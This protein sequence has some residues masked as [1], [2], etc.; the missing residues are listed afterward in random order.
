M[1]NYKHILIWL[2]WKLFY[3]IEHA[4]CG[5]IIRNL[6]LEVLLDYR[7]FLDCN[8][9]KHWDT[10]KQYYPC[11]YKKLRREMMYRFLIKGER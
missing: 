5:F 2:K 6:D 1:K 3:S 7:Y 9:L 8:D 10:F 11:A 4:T